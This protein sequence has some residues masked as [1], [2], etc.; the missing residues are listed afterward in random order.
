MTNALEITRLTMELDSL[1]LLRRQVIIDEMTVDDVQFGTARA[2]SG[3]LD[4]QDGTPSSPSPDS[5]EVEAFQLPPFEVPDVQ[6]ILEQE[7]LETLKLIE[8]IQTDIQREKESWEKRLKNLPGKA[9]FAKYKTRIEDLKSSTRGGTGAILRGVD[10]VQ[11]IKREIERDLDQLKSARKKFEEKLALLK[12]RIAQTKKAP[13]NDV[14]R[15]KEKYSLSPQSLAN[16]GQTL[17]GSI[18]GRS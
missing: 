16:L 1:Y 10:E 11:L 7:D 18:S 4:G 14:R 3:A 12:K 17:L 2:T 6:K 9:Q 15:L 8:A 13:K 5:D